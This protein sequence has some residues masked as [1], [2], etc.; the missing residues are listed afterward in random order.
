M[1]SEEEEF[2]ITVIIYGSIIFCGLLLSIVI[3][4]FA[5]RIWGL[6]KKKN[7]IKELYEK[8]RKNGQKGSRGHF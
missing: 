5:W 7:I 4:A 1:I 6:N 8:E 2:L 3:G